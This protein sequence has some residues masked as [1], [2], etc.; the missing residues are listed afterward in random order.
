[1]RPWQA[2]DP[3]R[4]IAHRGASRDHPENTRAAFDAALSQGCDA[5]ELDLQ[6]SRDGVPVVYHDR[7]LT[8]AGGG[9][10]RVAQ[11]DLSEL[12]RL[13][14]GARRGAAHRGQTI[15]TLEQVLRRYADRTRLLLEIKARECRGGSARHLE[16]LRSVIELVR[17]AEVERHVMLLCYDH[18]LLRASARA[19]PELPR[20]LNVK[21]RPQ[22]DA[23]LKR[24]IVSLQALSADVR[25]LTPRFAAAVRRA[26]CPLLVF[27]CNTPRAARAAVRARA[28]GIMTD[29]PGWLR[30]FLRGDTEGSD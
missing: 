14:P 2:E 15:P 3:I 6:L 7:T 4:V 28:I 21:P 30:R 1:V 16:L 10:R 23:D 9:R 24:R 5:I 22:L 17:R 18:A 27:T 11:L 8:R 26:G 20:V 19:A 25:T 29:R 12:R 13:D